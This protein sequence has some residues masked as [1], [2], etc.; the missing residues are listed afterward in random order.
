MRSCP[1]RFFLVNVSSRNFSWKKLSRYFSI[2]TNTNAQTLSQTS[3]QS[4]GAKSQVD[5]TRNV[6]FSGSG[7]LSVFHLGVASGLIER[8]IIAKSSKFAGASGGALVAGSLA[9]NIPTETALEAH[10]SIAADCRKNGTIGRAGKPLMKALQMIIPEN[11]AD[12]CSGKV[13]I[14]VSRIWPKPASPILLETFESRDRLLLALKTSCYIPYYL[15]HSMSIKWPDGHYVDGGFAQVVPLIP[16][17]VLVVP[18]RAEFLA[19]VMPASARR[20]KDL[21]S[22]SLLPDFPYAM[23]DLVRRALL[24]SSEKDTLDLFEW[25]RKAALAWAD[26]Q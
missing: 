7:F 19:P 11:G 13:K 18:F 25:G 23:P 24:P 26:R 5:M 4:F 16:S 15:E 3:G 20:S 2:Q 17:Y 14:A 6:S 21:I 1:G 22:P 10:L 8:K 9:S 12:L